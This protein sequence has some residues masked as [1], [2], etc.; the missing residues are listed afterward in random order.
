MWALSILILSFIQAKTMG[1]HTPKPVF[2][3]YSK[4]RNHNE[5]QLLKELQAAHLLGDEIL[6]VAHEKLHGSNFSLTT[7]GESLWPAK[8]S[9]YLEEKEAFQ[10]YRAN[11]IVQRFAAPMKQLFQRLKARYPTLTFRVSIIIWF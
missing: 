4:F 1:D 6:W 11:L 8:R 10:F 9:S 5:P 3:T 2:S 7:D